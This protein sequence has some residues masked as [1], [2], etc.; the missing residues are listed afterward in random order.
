M[1]AVVIIN[2]LLQNVDFVTA[3]DSHRDKEERLDGSEMRCGGNELLKQLLSRWLAKPV[4]VAATAE[5]LGVTDLQNGSSMQI[6]VW[7][8]GFP[9][10]RK[11]LF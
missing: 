10:R 4:A 11:Q 5:G 9:R 2:P 6:H 1:P 3:F 8:E 7:T